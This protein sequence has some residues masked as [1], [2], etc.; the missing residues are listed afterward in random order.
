MGE[1]LKTS[2]A[3]LGYNSNYD[4]AKYVG[5]TY[6]VCFTPFLFVRAVWVEE[7]VIA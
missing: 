1:S 7:G 5:T 4:I 2:L 3:V 6:C